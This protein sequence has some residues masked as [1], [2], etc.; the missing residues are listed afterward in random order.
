MNNSFD[1]ELQF[2]SSQV[3]IICGLESNGKISSKSAYKNIKKL[4]KALKKLKKE[5][6]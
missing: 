3:S 1:Q 6:I 4:W 5:S 2:F